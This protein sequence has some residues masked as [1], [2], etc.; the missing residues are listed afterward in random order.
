MKFKLKFNIAFLVLFLSLILFMV[1]SSVYIYSSKKT[2]NELSVYACNID[3]KNNNTLTTGLLFDIT[4]KY[5]EDASALLRTAKIDIMNLGK[6]VY[7]SL[8]NCYALIT[9]LRCL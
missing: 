1:I 4:R 6:L 3:N 2:I 5:A 9:K 7:N 8:S